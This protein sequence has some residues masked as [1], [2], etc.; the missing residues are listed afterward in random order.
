LASS[1]A[2]KSTVR[3]VVVEISVATRDPN[4][5]RLIHEQA[6]DVLKKV[7]GIGEVR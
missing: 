3:N 6:M 1:K 4:I 2:S 5:P 7:P